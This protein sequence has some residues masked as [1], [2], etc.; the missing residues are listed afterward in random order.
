MLTRGLGDPSAAY[1]FALSDPVGSLFTLTAI[2]HAVT[3]QM[4]T[5]MVVDAYQMLFDVCYEA[6][7]WLERELRS[8]FIRN[9]IDFESCELL[10]A[11]DVN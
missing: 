3:V 11:Q 2:G 6:S 5:G 1:P 9:P 10:C 7:R 4:G 8:A